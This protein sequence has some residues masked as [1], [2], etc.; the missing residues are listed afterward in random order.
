VLL[1]PPR[2]GLALAAW[3]GPVAV[4]L[5]GTGALVLVLRGWVRR[6]NLPVPDTNRPASPSPPG[7]RSA[8]QAR[9]E[10]DAVR[11]GLAR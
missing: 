6:G 1:E 5:L 11:K 9:A 4:L 2:R 7:D 3:L 8:A 10:L